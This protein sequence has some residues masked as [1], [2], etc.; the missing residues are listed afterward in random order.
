M[1]VTSN[2]LSHHPAPANRGIISRVKRLHARYYRIMV[3]LFLY[4]FYP[5]LYFFSRR[6]NRY[7]VMNVFRK[8]CGFLS[9]AA[10]GIFYVTEYE[11]QIDWSKTYIICP[12]HSS[13]IDITALTLL[14][15]NNFHFMGKDELLQKFPLNLFFKTIDIPVNRESKIS[16]FRAFKKAAHN[17]QNGMSLV[18]FPEGKIPDDYPPRLNEFKNGP[19]RL[20]I[21]LKI[22]I[23][24]V[25]LL[26]SWKL[27]WDTGLELGSKPGICHVYV[28]QPIDTA[29]LTL[30]QADELKDIVFNTINQKL[31]TTAYAD[32]FSYGW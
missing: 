3:G 14:T 9:S 30:E 18:I 4:I 23:I 19:F 32:W 5:F 17:L 2:S 28:H 29:H 24:P 8:I 20:A 27:L 7:P 25:T 15:K 26:D 21:E 31:T 13:N 6:E 11:Q 12:N 16:S 10:S 1:Q 22:P